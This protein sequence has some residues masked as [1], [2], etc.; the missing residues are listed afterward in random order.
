MLGVRRSTGDEVH[1]DPDAPEPPRPGKEKDDSIA[2]SD[3]R[4]VHLDTE[5]SFVLYPPREL[6]CKPRELAS[7]VVISV[8]P[9]Q[10][11]RRKAQLESLIVA[12]LR[13]RSAL[14]YFQACGEICPV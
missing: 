2:H 3:E 6:L 8:S 9:L 12:L 4:Q 1:R 7:D 5:R 14:N 13:R 10:K 11:E